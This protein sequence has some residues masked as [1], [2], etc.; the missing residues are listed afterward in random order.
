MTD[1]FQIAAQFEALPAEA[2]RR[3][4]HIATAIVVHQRMEDA[5]QAIAEAQML[6]AGTRDPICIAITGP[7]GS[8]KSS[9]LAIHEKLNPRD[10]TGD[11]VVIPV[12]RASV[13][14]GPSPKALAESLLFELG[15]PLA[16]K[17]T[18]ANMTKRLEGLI[19]K[20]GVKIIMLDEFQHFVARGGPKSMRLAA[21]YLK[22]L[23]DRTRVP[24][25][26]FGLDSCAVAFE[27]NEQLARRFSRRIQLRPF[28]WDVAAER[29][30]F[31]EFVESLFEQ[32]G[33][34]AVP[35]LGADDLDY[36]LHLAGAGTVGHLTLIIRAAARRAL[37]DSSAELTVGHLQAAF[38]QQA[39]LLDQLSF[40]PF[41]RKFEVAKAQAKKVHQAARREM[42]KLSLRDDT[43][44]V[45]EALGQRGKH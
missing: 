30:A 17:G 23:I 41:H 40:D 15:D 13:P 20:C 27:S 12:L 14:V 25:V 24:V 8:G 21:D 42:M 33:F 45:R 35:D 3:L 10:E 9:I 26:I 11:T 36:R 22:A 39:F 16:A 43:R 38:Q 32:L 34:V 5:I 18:L 31:R 28:D 6:S 1:A 44:P 2:H 19:Q 4:H 29:A 37:L 7:T